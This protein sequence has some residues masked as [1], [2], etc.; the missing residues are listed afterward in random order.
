MASHSLRGFITHG[1]TNGQFKAW[2]DTTETK[3]QHVNP[4][5][6]PFQRQKLQL[7]INALRIMDILVDGP[8]PIISQEF[9]VLRKRFCETADYYVE[10]IGDKNYW[11]IHHFIQEATLVARAS[12]NEWKFF[13]KPSILSE[14]GQYIYSIM[15]N[16]FY[17]Q[18]HEK[19]ILLGKLEEIMHDLS[20]SDSGPEDI[21]PRP[22]V[23]IP[24]VENSR[25]VRVF[26]GPST[27]VG[28]RVVP[29]LPPSPTVFHDTYDREAHAANM[30]KLDRLLDLDQDGITTCSI[31]P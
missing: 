28:A 18:S 2:A 25:R 15:T 9:K 16:D 11:T 17:Q 20:D 4:P 19:A 14:E 31:Q 22:F 29:R 26:V 13:H 7:C 24:P 3:I 6:S 10:G 1:T 5:I 21:L 8:R 23:K 27:T 30:A 12:Y